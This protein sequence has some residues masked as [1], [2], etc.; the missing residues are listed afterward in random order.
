[1]CTC[2]WVSVGNVLPTLCRGYG[3]SEKPPNKGDYN[4]SALK[5]DI[6]E[7]VSRHGTKP[8]CQTLVT[9]CLHV[10]VLKQIPAL[11]HE[12]CILVGHDWGGVIAWYVE[13]GVHCIG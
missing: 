4:L 7:L 2:C 3:D 1:M 13:M 10:L 6:V 9:A 11:G 5:Q 12:R 8:V